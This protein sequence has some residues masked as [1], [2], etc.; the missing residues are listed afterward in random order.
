MR[1]R[2]VNLHCKM[3]FMVGSL[4]HP[5]V[6]KAY[7]SQSKECETSD[8]AIDVYVDSFSFLEITFK[9]NT[10]LLRL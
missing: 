4:S 7:F 10:V 8:W 9:K 6:V 5:L 3:K 2:Y 1:P